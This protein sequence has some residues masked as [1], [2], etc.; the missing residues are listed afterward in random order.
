VEKKA[1]TQNG[2]KG[3]SRVNATTVMRWSLQLALPSLKEDKV[4]KGEVFFSDT[5]RLGP[6]S[7]HFTFH[8]LA[9]NA[10]LLFLGMNGP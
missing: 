9:F 7:P 6:C 10:P 3:P 5:T 1:L 4:T 8:L 2:S